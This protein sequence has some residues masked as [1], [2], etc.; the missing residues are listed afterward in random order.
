MEFVADRMCFACGP[1]NPIGLRLQFRQEGDAY[2][3]TFIA[4][5]AFQ[6]YHNVIHGGIVAT[7][8]DEVMARYVWA[9]YGPSATAKLEVRYRCP[10]PVGVP[11]EVRGWV[12]AERRG[13]RAV[14]TAAEARLEDGT[15]LAEATGLIIRLERPAGD[16]SCT[17]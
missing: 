5:Q 1:E 13:G 16:A 7:L 12:T 14:E 17:T 6:G 10:A 9:K 3:T 15:V 11:L 2:V 8:L 4:D